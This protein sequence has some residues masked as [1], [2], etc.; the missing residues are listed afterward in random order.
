VLK[1]LRLFMSVC[2]LELLALAAPAFAHGGPVASTTEGPVRGERLA[3][4]EAFRG[5]P[6]AAAPVGALGG[7]EDA[8]AQPATAATLSAW[9]RF[10]ARVRRASGSGASA[11]WSRSASR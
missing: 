2:C 11:P 5:I 10:C 1:R 3:G 4:V 9:I 8:E 7:D 6:Y